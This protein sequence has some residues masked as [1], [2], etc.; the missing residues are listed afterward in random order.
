[1]VNNPVIECLMN[2]RS[3]R[4]FEPEPVEPGILDLIL[5]AGTRA[6]TAGNLQLYTL[7]VVDDPAKKEALGV[8]D[9]PVAI[10][11]LADQYRIKRW[12]E[13]N[14]TAPACFN[15]LSNLLIGFWDAIIALHNITIAAESLGLGTCYYGGILAQDIY[16]LFDLPEYVFPAGMATIGYPA[17]SPELSD[18]LPLRAVVHRNGYRIPSET[19]IGQYYEQR[20]SLWYSLT[21]ELKQSL[22]KQNIRSIPQA[23]AVQKYSEAIVNQVSEGI[24]EN[25]IKSGFDID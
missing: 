23:I 2:H 24:L 13:L 17:E 16:E 25:L 9:A 20:E 1:M 15:R 8:P 12:F 10:V 14:D 19:D 4:K 22:A 21:D 5:K 3:I 7:I 18:R 11:A 6:A